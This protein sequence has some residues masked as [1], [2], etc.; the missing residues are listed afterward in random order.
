MTLRQKQK[1]KEKPYLNI[2]AVACL[3]L[4]LLFAAK[5]P[6]ILAQDSTN[7][8]DE[9]ISQLSGEINEKKKSADIL[10]QE[11]NAYEQQIK[12]KQAE[13]R[14]LNNQISILD[15]QVAKINLDI[16]A[17][18]IRIEQTQLE[19]Q[20]LNLEIKELENLIDTKKKQLGEYL[21]KIYQND[22]VS[23][24][25]VLL[26]NN[27]FSDFYDLIK[28]TQQINSDLKS[29][30]DKLKTDK[31]ELEIQIS[32]WNEKAELENTLKD[33]L[34]QQKDS[35]EE[36]STAKEI[37][38]VQAR[39]TQK[40]YQ[41]FQYQLQLEQQQINA[42]IT[43]LQKEIAKQLEDREV[44]ERFRGFGPARLAWP[45][46]PS[47]GITAYFHDADYPFRY[48]FEHPAIDI[49]A[50][51]GTPI[52]APES[53]FVGRVHFPGNT[54][55]SYLVLIHND[56]LSTV[57]GHISNVHVKENEFV[58]KG[59]VVAAS[60]GAPGSIGSGNLTT[61]PHLHFEVRLNGIPVNPLEYLP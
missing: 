2:L 10:Q 44:K 12:Q 36:N 55:Y 35:L 49:R 19:I 4:A 27:S 57:F 37:L 52:K 54:N 11:I 60:G 18:Q 25:E 1:D 32:N 41:N 29:T 40:Q 23:Q 6:N 5:A 43:N 7:S 42:D 47:R 46:D 9:K 21:R 3:T 53:G 34:Q 61:G 39:L 33:E 22:Q 14:S 31:T 50:Y 48:I 26:S 15:N 28:Y 59:Q 24:L 30:L 8:E 56:G 58:T 20:K 17:T 38:L 45:V 51:Q 16:E 13:A